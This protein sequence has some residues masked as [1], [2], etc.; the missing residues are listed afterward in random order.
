MPEFSRPPSPTDGEGREQTCSVGRPAVLIPTSGAERRGGLAQAV[1]PSFLGP[2]T[3]RHC[4]FSTGQVLPAPASLMFCVPMVFR[5]LPPLGQPPCLQ[6]HPQLLV[7]PTVRLHPPHVLCPAVSLPH[8]S[9]F[10]LMDYAVTLGT[11]SHLWGPAFSLLLGP[12]WDHKSCSAYSFQSLISVPAGASEEREPHSFPANK[13]LY[14]RD[15][16]SQWGFWNLSG[17]AHGRGVCSW[18]GAI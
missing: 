10:L 8:V 3:C 17:R 7:T 4:S 1:L 6:P 5:V 15:A 16:Q 12:N 11:D 9:L 13:G 14:F 2:V 18:A